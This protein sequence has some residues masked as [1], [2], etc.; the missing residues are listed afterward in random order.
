MTMGLAVP[1]AVIALPPPEGVAVA[2]YPVIG[3]PPSV[4][5]GVN[6]TVAWALP[7]VAETA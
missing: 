6:V 2:V 5:G 3:E 1:G 7:A 4:V